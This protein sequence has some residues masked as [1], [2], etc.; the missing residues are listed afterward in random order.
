MGA[1]TGPKCQRVMGTGTG[2]RAG[3]GTTSLLHSQIVLPQ[4]SWNDAP[5]TYAGYTF[6]VPPICK[7][8]LNI[9]HVLIHV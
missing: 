1:G 5:P 4:S 7:S 2:T 9:L 6:T 3:M 8:N